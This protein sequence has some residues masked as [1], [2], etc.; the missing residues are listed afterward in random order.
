M[1]ELSFNIACGIVVLILASVLVLILRLKPAPLRMPS[2]HTESP[3]SDEIGRQMAVLREFRNNLKAER[4]RANLKD[5]DDIIKNYLSE[6]FRLV[7]IGSC[8][9][10]RRYPEQHSPSEKSFSEMMKELNDDSSL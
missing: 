6:R 1:N 9:S 4:A 2:R 10:S 5:A 3:E 8:E 7:E